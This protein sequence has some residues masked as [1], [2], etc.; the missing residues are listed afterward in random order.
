MIYKESPSNTTNTSFN[1]SSSP[2]K[3]KLRQYKK[4][5]T[6][7]TPTRKKA[8]LV[9]NKSISTYS[10]VENKEFNNIKEY[11]NEGDIIFHVILRFHLRKID[12]DNRLF[13]R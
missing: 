10:M 2:Q 1:S 9:E 7:K 6:L 13:V 11:I 5:L 8:Y 12:T 3:K 4:H